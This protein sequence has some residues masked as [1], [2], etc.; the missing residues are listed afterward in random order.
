MTPLD[1]NSLLDGILLDLTSAKVEYC[2]QRNYLGYPGK[3]SGDVDLVISA[4][5]FETA[6]EVCIQ[7]ADS[8]GWKVFMQYGSENIVYIGFCALKIP[9]RFVL[10]IEFFNG[11]KWKG[12]EF[13]PVDRILKNKVKF[14]SYYVVSPVHETIITL[15][16]HLLYNGLVFN[17]YRH[18]LKFL[19]DQNTDLIQAELTNI[20]SRNIS[21]FIVRCVN[22]DDWHKI[23]R[24]SHV[25]KVYLIFKTLTSLPHIYH[26]KYIKLFV[27]KSTKP[28]GLIIHYISDSLDKIEVGNLIL[29]YAKKYHIMI[30]PLKKSFNCQ[31][32]GIKKYVEQVK[33]S[34]GIALINYSNEFYA[35][36][37][38]IGSQETF[39]VIIY[40]MNNNSKRISINNEHREVE[41]GMSE[42]AEIFWQFVLH[43]L[44]LQR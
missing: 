37:G 19:F 33:A 11:G 39:K 41:S 18:R 43:K 40:D 42:F 30:P 12:I 24:V 22:N 6:K 36:R 21:V 44:A 15:V 32:G 13:L 20:F 31:D 26:F 9:E 34:G 7:Y 23:E 8:N 17:K 1:V 10:V 25:L 28:E 2:I 14:K 35:T 16:H 3:I 5:H 4:E 27:R 38:L 29:S